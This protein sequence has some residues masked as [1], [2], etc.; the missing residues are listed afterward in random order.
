MRP[1]GLA[2][3]EQRS[4]AKSG[5]YSYEN[6]HL[7]AFSPAEEAAF[8]A[9]AAAWAWFESR[10]QSFRTA[11]NLVGGQRQAGRDAPAAVRGARRGVRGRPD[12]EAPDAAGAQSGRLAGRVE[13]PSRCVL[14]S[15]SPT[16]GQSLVGHRAE[17]A[18]L[19]EHATENRGV[20][21][22]NSGSR[23][24]LDRWSRHSS[25]S[26]SVG[27]ASPCQGEGRG[28]ESRLPLHFFARDILDSAPGRRP[29]P[30]RL[31]VGQ[32]TLDP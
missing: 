7:A 26:G 8:R 12:A 21:S 19:V 28:F 31:V 32:R 29:L 22:S 11:G 10:P 24:H 20:A 23:H 13:G 25:G 16:G 18:Q 30:L 3:F 1:A 27:R 2:A 15:P 5:V 9:D 17:I 4:E 6:R 14:S